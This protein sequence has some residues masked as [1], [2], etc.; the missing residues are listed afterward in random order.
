MK[1]IVLFIALFTTA[2]MG[3]TTAP[4]FTITTSDNQTLQLY[5]QFISQGKVVVLEAFF[6]TCPPCNT[7]APLVQ[8]LYSQMLAAYPGKV[9]FILLS[10]LNSDTNIKVGQY[11]TAKGLTMPGAGAN[12]G[13]TA[14]LQPYTSG[15]FGQFLGTP[16]FIVIAPNTGEVF[17]DVRGNSA[18][19][20]MTLLGQK[21]ASL[22]QPPP[23]Y[24]PLN[25]YF[26]NNLQS[27]T[28]KVTAPGFDSTFSAN[29]SYSVSNINAL[30]NKTYT[31]VPQKNDNPLDGV[32]TYDLVLISKH[33]LGIQALQ[34]PWQRLAADVNCSGTITTLDIV[35]AR[36]LI[37][38]INQTLPC[39]SWRFSPDSDTS[40]NGNC[41]QFLGVK[42]GDVNIAPC[43]QVTTAPIEKSGISIHIQ[44]RS[45]RAGETVQ[46]NL[47]V[48]EACS[49]EGLQA[50]LAFDPQKITL[51]QIGS[52]TL[53]GFD[54]NAFN[55][56]QTDKGIAPI[57]WVGPDNPRIEA[58]ATI[59]TLRITAIQAGKLSEMIQLSPR[60]EQ[61]SEVYDDASDN[62]RPLEFVWRKDLEPHP[63]QG[64]NFNISPNPSRGQFVLST[65]SA[66]SKQ[67]LIA[68]IDPRGAVE[69]QETY[70][71]LEGPNH[72]TIHLPHTRSGMY[73]L[74]V[75]GAFAGKVLVF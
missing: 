55:L 10:T 8:S 70:N 1:N 49:L 37:L 59:L 24:C 36:K 60:L 27:V 38:G 53:R 13:S 12:G 40:S 71:M 64:P 25:D 5:Q 16:T 29:N 45:L 6:T 20:T 74:R 18:S 72:W 69:F 61:R 19:E 34:C 22:Q 28:L 48:E 54:F 39:G 14:A 66:Q 30:K 33:I 23:I 56:E 44:D 67:I 3:A 46:V 11:K 7:H 9:E 65:F 21:I 43:D 57:V 63:P 47:L 68:L 32:T 50:T 35:T 4:N 75:D 62:S 41:V 17:F 15:Q 42:L 51:D 58:G 2:E 52:E 73:Y 31:I 26:N